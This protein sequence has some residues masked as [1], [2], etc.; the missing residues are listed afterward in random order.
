MITQHVPFMVIF[1]KFSEMVSCGLSVSTLKQS[2]MFVSGD[3]L[4]M[5]VPQ[6]TNP[7]GPLLL[8]IRG[9]KSMRHFINSHN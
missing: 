5:V 3:M 2:A 8:S 9:P 6:L 1:M 4:V 7:A